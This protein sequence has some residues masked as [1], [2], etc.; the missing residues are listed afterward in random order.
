MVLELHEEGPPGGPFFFEVVLELH[1]E[2]P[3]GGPF[4]VE[5]AWKLLFSM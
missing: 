5:L 1:E 2:G 3:P 4:L